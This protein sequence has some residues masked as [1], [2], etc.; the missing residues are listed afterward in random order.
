[1]VDLVNT[2]SKP[3]IGP[4]SYHLFTDTLKGSYYA[5]P[6]VDAPEVTAEQR[7]AYPEYYGTNICMSLPLPDTV[8]PHTS[9]PR[10]SV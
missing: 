4:G 9:L 5:N 7:Q 2:T 8:R 1:M 3:S 10:A 6:M